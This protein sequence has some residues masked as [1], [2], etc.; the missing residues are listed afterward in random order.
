MVVFGSIKYKFLLT[1]VVCLMAGLS[2]AQTDLEKQ[3][4][5]QL[6]DSKIGTL[7]GVEL[8][9]A[10]V[11][12]LF[13]MLSDAEK[14]NINSREK[15]SVFV[16]NALLLE[17]IQ[18]QVDDQKI[19]AIPAVSRKIDNSRNVILVDAWFDLLSTPPADF[20]SD[21]QINAVFEE[22][23]EKLVVPGRADLSQIFVSFAKF[24]GDSVK[25]NELVAS[26]VDRIKAKEASFEELATQ[27]SEH[28]PSAASGGRLG[29]AEIKTIRPEF[30]AAINNLKVG[31]AG[32]AVTGQG[33]HL[34]LVN[35]LEVARK[36][37][38][39]EARADLVKLLRDAYRSKSR[40][41]LIT[42]LKKK[43]VVEE[44]L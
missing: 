28:E 32:T 9:G 43:M 18:N 30:L 22:N 25:A 39:V 44:F 42:R 41:E 40:V 35:N 34:I 17:Y 20:P 15:L 19:A 27:Y 23:K 13:S 12:Q 3:F 38:P 4:D 14:K 24:D 7:E 10:R 37:T 21:E 31:Q 11:I 2:F 8:T 16:E 29:W 5:I 36:M 26:I 33:I 6:D 1:C